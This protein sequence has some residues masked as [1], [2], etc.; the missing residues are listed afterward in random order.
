MI[1]EKYYLRKINEDDLKQILTW[2]NR[3]EI[4]SCMLNDQVISWQEHLAWFEGLQKAT[5]RD[6][7]MFCIGNISIGIVNFVDIDEQNNKQCSWGFYIG[8]QAAPKGAGMLLGYCAIEYAFSHYMLDSIVSEV[9]DFNKIS[10]N[11]HKRLLFTEQG[12]LKDKIFRQNCYYDLLQFELEKTIWEQG[13]TDILQAALGKT[14][15]I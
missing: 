6:C 9:I 13:K 8:Q 1:M 5:N 10:I 3:D 15:N 11:F 7:Q 4:R 12:V 2:R 14:K